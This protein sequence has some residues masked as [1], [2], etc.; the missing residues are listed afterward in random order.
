VIACTPYLVASALYADWV[1]RG[2]ER[3]HALTLGSI[4]TALAFLLGSALLVRGPA[5]LGLAALLWALAYLPGAALLLVGEAARGALA[6]PRFAPRV[7]LGHLRESIH[8]TLSGGVM[9]LFALLPVLWLTRRGPADELGWFAAP[10]RLLGSA[11]KAANL[12][13]TAFFPA[14]AEAHGR[15]RERFRALYRLS[16]G[17]LA[18]LAAL[19]VAATCL[20]AAPLV[21]LLLGPEYAP[22]EP[23][24]RLL[25]VALGLRLLRIAE[26]GPLL[27]GGYQRVKARV[28]LIG[29]VA[30]IAFLPLS[31]WMRPSLAMA[32][33]VLL[34]ELVLWLGLF[35]ASRATALARPPAAAPASGTAASRQT[36]G[37]HGWRKRDRPQG[38][39]AT[40][41]KYATGAIASMSQR[42]SRAPRRHR[43]R[44]PRSAS[45]R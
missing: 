19:G 29:P 33:A 36:A 30:L 21:R 2:L 45:P 37:I 44:L 40:R 43:R 16:L 14:L 27:A 39:P 1:V 24:A 20:L 5:D 4:A 34:A 10:Y 38:P 7:L 22:S 15:D 31:A 41:R 26:E 11:G 6:W 28:S 9:S 23:V 25:G 32:A 3:F 12:L 35:R 13:Q 18:A 42:R 8:Y 17:A